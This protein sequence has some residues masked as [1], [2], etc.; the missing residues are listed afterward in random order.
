M[1]TSLRPTQRSPSGSSLTANYSRPTDGL[2][3][4]EFRRL[5]RESGSLNARGEFTQWLHVF[6]L[7]GSPDGVPS[8]NLSRTFPWVNLMP[9]P[10]IETLIAMQHMTKMAQYPEEWRDWSYKFE[11]VRLEARQKKR[12]GPYWMLLP[13]FSPATL[14]QTLV[15]MKRRIHNEMFRDADPWSAREFERKLIESL[16]PFLIN[17]VEKT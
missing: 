13:N 16:E 11:E 10:E 7:E 3:G 5:W 2:P 17:Q 15:G 6:C 1:E 8:V 12:F 4:D 9:K 14:A